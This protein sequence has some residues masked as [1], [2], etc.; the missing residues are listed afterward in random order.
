MRYAVASSAG[1]PGRFIGTFLPKFATVSGSIVEGISGVQIGPGAT[2][3]ARMPLSASNYA[4]PAVK[5]WMAPF[6]VA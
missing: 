2:Q 6:V 5:F 4:R 3:L 1:C